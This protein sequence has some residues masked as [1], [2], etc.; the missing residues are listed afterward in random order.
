[1]RPSR[2]WWGVVIGLVGLVALP[3]LGDE[4]AAP[5]AGETIH[6]KGKIHGTYTVR[7]ANPDTGSTYQL[8][9]SGEVHPLGRSEA[10]GSFHTPGNIANGHAE[11]TL[12]LSD[13]KGGVT[14]TLVGPAQPAFAPPPSQFAFTITGGTGKFQGAQGSGT[15]TLALRESQP[16][17]GGK[18]APAPSE[19]TLTFAATAESHIRVDIQ[20]VLHAHVEAP[21]GETTGTTIPEQGINWELDLGGNKEFEALANQLDGKV[22][23]ARGTL[24]I[25]K[26]VAIPVRY[27]IKVT[28]LKAGHEK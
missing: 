13:P 27:I 28:S 2:R 12:T 26:G 4:K 14:L 18:A 8:T 24:N 3:A 19:F 1:M 25:S 15:A 17:A 9:A 6:L 16:P 20:G 23:D 10:T 21:G 22:A 5:A 7:K 11:G